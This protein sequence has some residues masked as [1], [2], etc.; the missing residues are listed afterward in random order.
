MRKILLGSLLCLSTLA[1]AQE[2]EQTPLEQVQAET[3]RIGSIVDNLNKW[4]I[5]GYIQGDLQIGQKDAGFKVGATKADADQSVLNRFGIRRGRIKFANTELELGQVKGTAVFQLDIT[6]KGVG[7]KDAYFT[8]TDPWGGW[9]TLKAG[10]FDRPF[11]YEVSYSSSSRETPE[12]S[13]G[14][15]TLFPDERDLGAMFVIQAPKGHVLNSFKLETGLFAGNGIKQETDNRK[16]WISHLTYKKSYDN[17]QWGLGGSLYLGGV[18]QGT[19]KVYEMAGKEFVAVNNA[20]IGEYSTRCYYGLDGQFLLN[21]GA[22][23]T[24][25]RA[26][27]IA[28]KQPG[29]LGDSKSPNSSTLPTIDT[30]R[31][32]FLSYNIYLIQDLGETKH[33]LVAKFD[34]YDPNTKLSGDEVGLGGSGKG[35]VKRYNLGF[36]YLYRMSSNFRLMAYYD[37]AYNEKTQNIAGYNSNIKDNIFTLRLQYKF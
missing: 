2:V 21:S 29:A 24:S 9:A 22:G 4:K 36:G 19:N 6:E 15:L 26:E 14:C 5:S 16:D 30:Y 3:E 10:V 28:G 23:L 35:D 27:M 1:M 25:L 7:F 11:G 8:L 31:R 37:M 33:S 32:D 17:F 18:Y 13:T 12:R 20:K 34:S